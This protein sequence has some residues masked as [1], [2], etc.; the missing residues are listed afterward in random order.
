VRRPLIVVYADQ[1]IGELVRAGLPH[2]HHPGGRQFLNGW[3]ILRGNI[4]GKK[5]RAGHRGTP[6]TLNKSFAA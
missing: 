6:F 3:T 1:S 4:V 5:P 2:E